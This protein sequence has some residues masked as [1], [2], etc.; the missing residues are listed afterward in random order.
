MPTTGRPISQ[1]LHDIAGQGEVSYSQ[2]ASMS[3]A[4]EDN[5]DPRNIIFGD[6]ARGGFRRG[7]PPF[8]RGRG[9]GR[10]WH[11]PRGRGRGRAR[12]QGYHDNF[13][14]EDWNPY[15]PLSDI[16]Y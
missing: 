15:W 7:A 9:R 5:Q 13:Y 16:H 14:A 2:A 3:Y 12:Y 4:Y 8:R 6:Q 11:A 1:R 10:A